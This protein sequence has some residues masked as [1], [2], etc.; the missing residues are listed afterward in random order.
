MFKVRGLRE[1]FQNFSLD[2]LKYSMLDFEVW[3]VGSWSC[4]KSQFCSVVFMFWI[5][6]YFLPEFR[7]ST[8]AMFPQPP[9]DTQP[10]N[11]YIITSSVHSTCFQNASGLSPCCLIH[12]TFPCV[13]CASRAPQQNRAG[14]HHYSVR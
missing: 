14:H 9:A 10:Q 1:P 6:S 8:C 11:E 3:I 4:S 5:G 12:V 7:P 2:F 13:V